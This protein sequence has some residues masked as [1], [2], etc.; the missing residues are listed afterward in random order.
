MSICLVTIARNENLYLNEWLSYH[1]TI[2]VDKVYLYCNDDDPA[3]MYRTVLPWIESGF[4]EFR[5][6]P[7]IGQQLEAYMHWAHI[8]LHDHRWV[9]F[10]DVDE[11][12]T[13]KRHH[14][15]QEYLWSFPHDVDVVYL[16]WFNFGHSGHEKPPAGRV[17]QLFTKRSA[18]MQKQTKI[19]VR[20]AAMDLGFLMSHPCPIQHGIGYHSYADNPFNPHG[21]KRVFAD[22]SPFLRELDPSEITPE[23]SDRLRGAA[24]ISHYYMR[25]ANHFQE[26]VD[27][28][29]A[30]L[31]RTGNN[32]FLLNWKEKLDS[33]EYLTEMEEANA[34][35]DN[36]LRDWSVVRYGQPHNDVLV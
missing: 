10:L 12:I 2:G 22:G 13:L 24:S 26:R 9:S 19:L 33:G 7:H 5:H 18:L 36:H 30:L 27:R 20:S 21:V 14:S 8:H 31:A 35:E 3:S 11:F 25:H 28:G 15:L 16:N 4:I 34:V 32:C 1:R 23:I 17:L 29:L 6:F